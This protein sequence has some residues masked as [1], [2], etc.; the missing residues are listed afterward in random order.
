[1]VKHN[2]VVIVCVRDL[3]GSKRQD[4]RKGEKE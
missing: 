3:G 2:K 4:A 1:L